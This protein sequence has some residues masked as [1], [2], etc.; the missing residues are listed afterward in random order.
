MSLVTNYGIS[1]IINE[2]YSNRINKGGTAG[3]L[4]LIKLRRSFFMFEKAKLEF[5]KYISNYDM[6]N[7]DISL[8]YHHS[9]AVSE[10]MGEL[11]FRLNLTKEQIELARVIGLLHDIGRFEQIKEFNSQVDSKTID[12][13]DESVKYLFDNKH[14]RDF[15]EEKKYDKIIKTAIKNHNKYKIP[16][17]IKDEEVL[18]FTKMI[19]DMDKVD[20]YKQVS[21]NYEREFNA[22]EVTRKVLKDFKNE[23]L[24][25]LKF[26]KTKTDATL[27]QLAFIFDINF[28]E[29]FD[30]LVS[31]DNFDLYLS[32]VEVE[33][34]SEKLWNKIKE[35]CFD[36]INRG[37]DK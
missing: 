33:E 23:K 12:H 18:L 36:K 2:E 1:V 31:T 32:M 30:I 29:S 6:K 16:S 10:L 9:L 20:I 8:K 22:S 24:I 28:N 15:I 19:R 3:K 26:R 17:T 11:A 25:D 35:L 37:V 7:N 21:I 14:I 34:H 5:D 27:A 13:A 4:V